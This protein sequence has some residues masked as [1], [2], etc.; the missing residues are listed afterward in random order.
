MAEAIDRTFSGA[1]HRARCGPARSRAASPRGGSR[2]VRGAARSRRNVRRRM[3]ASC[4]RRRSTDASCSHRSG[5][6]RPRI[7]WRCA[8]FDLD[9]RDRARAVVPIGRTDGRHLG[10]STRRSQRRLLRA[11]GRGVQRPMGPHADDHSVRPR[12]ERAPADRPRDP[13]RGGRNLSLAPGHSDR[14]SRRPRR[15]VRSRAR[16]GAQPCARRRGCR[17]SGRDG[18]PRARDRDRRLFAGSI[19]ERSLR[20]PDDSASNRR[21]E[22]SVFVRRCEV[23]SALGRT[24]GAVATGSQLL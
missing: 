22:F 1:R 5:S 16:R 8:R 19:R 10:T 2:A 14:A 17:H 12:L 23:P 7:G 3:R 20:S 21:V 9:D 24:S 13:L 6:A 11:S 4:R 18:R 15:R